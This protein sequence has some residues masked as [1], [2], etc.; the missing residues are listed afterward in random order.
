MFIKLEHKLSEIVAD[1]KQ[2]LQ[3]II[4]F[5]D[6]PEIRIRARIVLDRDQEIAEILNL[7]G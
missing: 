7:S 5:S 2:Q 3:K 1:R 4:K 6:D